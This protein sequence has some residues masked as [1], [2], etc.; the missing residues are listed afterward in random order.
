MDWHSEEGRSRL[1]KAFDEGYLAARGV[2]TLGRYQC[3][4]QGE[5]A[6]AFGTSASVKARVDF[7]SQ[8]IPVRNML[9]P[10]FAD[11]L[12]SGDLLPLP[13]PEDIATWSALLRELERRSGIVANPGKPS[14]GWLWTSG[15]RDPA[16]RRPDEQPFWLLVVT[17]G[18]DYTSRH[19]HGLDQ[20][21]PAE[22]L[23][24]AL[25]QAKAA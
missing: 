20:V 11:V 14:T 3:E 18:P 4:L 1:R 24:E 5:Q 21:D 8:G 2:F 13:D 19:F 10:M 23:V 25:I 15:P 16:Y 17:S 9:A 12:S 6:L 7:G 22:A